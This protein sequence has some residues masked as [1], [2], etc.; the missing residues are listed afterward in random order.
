MDES[1]QGIFLSTVMKF[2]N[3]EIDKYENSIYFDVKSVVRESFANWYN[4]ELGGSE[5]LDSDVEYSKNYELLNPDRLFEDEIANN[6]NVQQMIYFNK[7][8]EF[9]TWL[10][11]KEDAQQSNTNEPADAYSK[12][13]GVIPQKE[14]PAFRDPSSMK[15]PNKPRSNGSYTPGSAERRNKNQKVFGNKGELV[16]YNLL[17][18]QFGE[19]NV[20]PKSEAFVEIGILKPGQASSGQY[21]L[22]Y[23]DKSGTE[24]FV[25]VK[26]GDGKSFI[27]SPGELD[28]A[29]QNPD[30]FKLFLVYE[31]DSGTPKYIELPKKFWEDK[32]FRKTEIIERIEFEF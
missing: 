29:K 12:Y 5:L 23:M 27:I 24:F 16:I 13:K 11:A 30:Q 31:I 6:S 22:S 14:E 25:E 3:F 20:Y 10:A 26:T 1:L 32:K 17:C 18:E 4:N 9:E 15:G 19:E 7:A 28:F 21:D 2:E 8:K